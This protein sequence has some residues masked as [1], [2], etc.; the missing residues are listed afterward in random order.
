MKLYGNVI[1]KISGNRDLTATAVDMASFQAVAKNKNVKAIQVSD[2]T[3]NIQRNMGLLIANNGKI[4]ALGISRTD[5]DTEMTL[6]DRVF[7]Q[8]SALGGVLSKVNVASALTGKVNI[9][10]VAA[11]QLSARLADTKVKTVSIADSSSNIVAAASNLTINIA[12]VNTVNV[13]SVRP[14]TMDAADYQTFKTS[15]AG[16]L[17]KITST[18]LNA[19]RNAFN[20]TGA[21]VAASNTLGLDN[22]VRS[23]AVKDTTGTV[24]TPLAMS[25]K[26]TRVALEMTSSQLNTNLTN[27]VA[28]GS[29]LNSVKI[30]D[31]E[32]VTMD[33]S[34]VLDKAT[35][36]ALTKMTGSTDSPL[37][38]K[39]TS[40]KLADVVG[41]IA[42]RQ[43]TDAAI[44]DNVANLLA[45]SSD[46]FAA[47]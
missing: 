9:T 24:P 15:N 5:A 17:T 28:M 34:K 19:L 37:N 8:A 40:A 10:G 47:W 29:K 1:G 33:S 27:I 42:N 14:R 12:K 22:N 45:F 25:S 41:L 11:S 44:S 23:I 26:V 7:N 43:V 21:T 30:T 13:T 31:Q 18:N 36:S 38:V 20:V 35:S 2:S 39:V 46:D 6:T 32:F 3:A 16:L 4:P